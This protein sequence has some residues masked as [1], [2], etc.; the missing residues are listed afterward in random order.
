MLSAI[1]VANG[2]NTVVFFPRKVKSP[3]SFP[4]KGIFGAISINT[5]IRSN[6]L[7]AKI[8]MRAICGDTGI[9]LIN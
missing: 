9:E 8:N 3:G 2:K 4:K 7:P 5:P 1:Q 6:M